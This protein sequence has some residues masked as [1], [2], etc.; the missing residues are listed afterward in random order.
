MRKFRRILLLTAV[1]AGALC[2]SALA[3]EPTEAGVY[4]MTTETG[5]T[6]TP[7][8]ADGTEITKEDLG[9]DYS[10]Y[11]AG[12]VKF[13]V[14]ATGLT[15][16]SQYLLL[17]VSGDGAP[18]ADNIVYIDQQAA[19]ANGTVAF[20]AYP[21]ALDKGS[22]RIFLLGGDQTLNSGPAA[23]FQAYVPYTLGDVNDDGTIDSAD[24]LE[25][26]LFFVESKTPTETE[27]LAADVNKDGTIDSYDALQMLRY[28]VEEIHSFD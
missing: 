5:I 28:F 25:A 27:R 18:G 6:V 19:D 7:Q 24:A 11:Y 17:M 12:A 10:D 20:T 1:L 21:Q 22:Y 14:E 13:G 15:A 26:L 9:G 2:V 23:S 8:T 4:G 3:A 16:G